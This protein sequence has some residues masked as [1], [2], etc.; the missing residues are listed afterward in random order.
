MDG[1]DAMEQA[2]LLAERARGRVSPNPAVGCVV[3]ADG[4]VVGQGWTRPPPGPHAE[5]VALDEAAAAA[6]GATVYVTLEPCGHTGRTP[7]CAQ[8]LAG[9]GVARVV[10][11]VAD[12]HRLAAGG[13]QQLR[14]AGIEVVHDAAAEPAAARQL[15]AH[16]HAARTGRPLVVLKLATS[17]D[18][19]VAAADGS[20]RWLTGPAARE[21]AHRARADADAVVVGVDTVLADDPELTVRLPDWDGPQPVRVVLDGAAR[22]PPSAAVA[23]TAAAPT[24][25]VVGPEAAPQRC[26]ALARAGVEIVTLDAPRAGGGDLCALLA[27]L[28]DRGVRAVLV[29]G[30]ARVAGSVV[31]AGLADRLEVHLSAAL[32]G[33][34]GLPALR[35][36][37]VA[38][39]G[40]A[41]R[42]TLDAVERLDDDVVVSYLP[43]A[44]EE[45]TA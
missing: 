16:L 7:P 19:R 20:S 22:T 45:R 12:P 27:A 21:R 34:A 13:A 23:D 41:P 15:A 4:A 44:A 42:Y 9:A 8:A 17:L 37:D 5:A 39:L 33:E 10:Y 28:A 36:L 32:L 14:A 3:V 11:A 40:Q 43:R 30:G 35:G 18:G 2:L 1:R 6:R 29:E 25:V 24:M 31:A 38:T 26:A